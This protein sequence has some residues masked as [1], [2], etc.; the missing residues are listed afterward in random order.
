MPEHMMNGAT[1]DTAIMIVCLVGSALFALVFL[2]LIIIQTVLQARILR[3]VREL[4][5]K[6]SQPPRH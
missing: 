5:H 1:M 6:H 4:K 2:V 3:E